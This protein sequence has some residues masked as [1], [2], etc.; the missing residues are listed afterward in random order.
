MGEANAKEG[1]MVV[2]MIV[3][4]GNGVDFA[5]TVDVSEL[6]ANHSLFD[7]DNITMIYIGDRWVQI[8]LS[9]N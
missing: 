7:Y 9:D 6:S 4:A 8:A 3:Q 1:D 5:D 2:V